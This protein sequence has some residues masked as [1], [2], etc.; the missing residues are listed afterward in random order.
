MSWLGSV[1]VRWCR[2]C[3]IISKSE[4]TKPHPLPTPRKVTNSNASNSN[5]RRPLPKGRAGAVRV[6]KVDPATLVGSLTPEARQALIES[7]KA[8]KA[9]AQA[10]KATKATKRT[11][12]TVDDY[13]GLHLARLGW[14][15]PYTDSQAAYTPKVQDRFNVCANSHVYDAIIDAIKEMGGLEFSDVVILYSELHDGGKINSFGYI[16]QH[17][18]NRM[19]QTL[20]V[21]GANISAA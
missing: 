12:L 20:T 7:A 21:A 6:T 1:G 17:V 18:A 11:R 2:S 8:A 13:T 16:L 3:C 5:S 15:A 10:T 9:A 14:K 19:G 4:G